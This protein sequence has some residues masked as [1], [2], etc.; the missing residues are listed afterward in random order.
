MRLNEH[1]AHVWTGG[2]FNGPLP[3]LSNLEI[4]WNPASPAGS[5]PLTLLKS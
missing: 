5:P 3:R 1:S 4:T 2:A